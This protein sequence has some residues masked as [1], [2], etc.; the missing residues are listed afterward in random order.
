MFQEDFLGRLTQQ[1]RHAAPEIRFE[2]PLIG[3]GRSLF[4]YYTFIDRQRIVIP[5]LS[6]KFL[7]DLSIT[8]AYMERFNCN[9]EMFFHYLIKL[10]RDKSYP[11]TP[12]RAAL[13]IPSNALEDAFVDDVS[14]KMLKSTIFFL[15]GHE[16][17]HV[18]YRHRGYEQISKA[19]AQR[20]ESQSDDFALD[21]MRRI[22]VDPMGLALFFATAS[23]QEAVPER[24]GSQTA[25]D[26]NIRRTSTHPLSGNRLRNISRYMRKHAAAFARLQPDQPAYIT[27]I[28]LLAGEI[29]K[30]GSSLSDGEFRKF[31]YDRALQTST[32]QLQMACD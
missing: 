6:V 17:G 13:G 25:F 28:Q 18:M 8:Y 5:I 31:M 4:E 27:A 19:E 32:R 22:G 16:Y 29:D 23:A 21:V 30:T 10:L 26:Q 12:P 14:Q 24:F 15:L 7:D 9:R 2:T 1:E 20:Q 11:L 3:A